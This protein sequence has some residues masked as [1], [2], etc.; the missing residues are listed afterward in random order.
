M[1]QK[2][3]GFTRISSAVR[4]AVEGALTRILTPRR[5]IDVLRDIAAAKA[6]GRPYSIVFV[7]VNGVGKSTNLAKVAYWLLQNNISVRPHPGRRKVC[8]PVLRCKAAQ[9]TCHHILPVVPVLTFLSGVLSLS[10]S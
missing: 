10:P 4:A 8:K 2:L 6:Q 1:G 5:S 7:G 3:A 9:C